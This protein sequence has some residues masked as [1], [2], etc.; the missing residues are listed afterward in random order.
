V[1][2]R[3][4]YT[5]TEPKPT[6]LDEYKQQVDLWLEE[7]P[8]SAVRVLEKLTEQGFTGKYS[9]VKEY[10][11]GK[12]KDMEEKATVGFETIRGLQGQMDWGI[13]EECRV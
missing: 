6:K 10:V 7:A 5:L 8:Y 1:P 3:P 4:E 13:F 12:K 2:Q 11:G 9:M